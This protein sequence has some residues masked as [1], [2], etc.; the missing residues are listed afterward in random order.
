[1]T[2]CEDT[3]ASGDEKWISLASVTANSNP[4]VQRHRNLHGQSKS[5]DI[6]LLSPP[7]SPGWRLLL[8]YTVSKW[9]KLMSC[10]SGRAGTRRS[11][12]QSPFFLKNWSF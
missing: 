9:V 7:Y 4:A 6:T 11:P 12:A 2:S 1:M 3:S 10:I 5:S 8:F